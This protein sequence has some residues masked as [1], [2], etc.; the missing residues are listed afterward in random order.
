MATPVDEA[1]DDYAEM[2]V[3]TGRLVI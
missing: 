1:I 2:F 3:K